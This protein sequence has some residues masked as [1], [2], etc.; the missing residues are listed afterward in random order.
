[1][2][3]VM[4]YPLALV[5]QEFDLLLLLFSGCDIVRNSAGTWGLENTHTVACMYL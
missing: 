3:W 4:N 5:L 1:M 2:Q